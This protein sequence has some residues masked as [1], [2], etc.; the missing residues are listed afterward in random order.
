MS[1]LHG[2]VTIAE[3][4]H[5]I[6][7]GTLRVRLIDVSRADAPAVVISEQTIPDIRVERD[8]EHIGFELDIPDLQPGSTY[9]LEAHLDA[10][11]T[12]ETSVGDYRT[13]EHIG[14]SPSDRSV[15]VPVRPVG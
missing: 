10:S 14:V 3:A 4:V 15:T 9:A 6:I 8:G 5:P 2:D 7:N 13:T 11:G 12:G 1:K